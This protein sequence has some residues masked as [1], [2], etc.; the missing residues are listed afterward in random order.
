MLETVQLISHRNMIYKNLDR[1]KVLVTSLYL[2]KSFQF[3][4]QSDIFSGSS[5]PRMVNRKRC[6][7]YAAICV[8]SVIAFGLQGNSSEHKLDR[9]WNTQ[10]LCNPLAFTVK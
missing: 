10:L 4:L 2:Q 6:Y 1:S 3:T 9:G 5:M 7:E 8:T